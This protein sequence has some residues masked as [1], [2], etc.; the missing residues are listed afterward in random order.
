MNS[1]LSRVAQVTIIGDSDAPSDVCLA[2]EQIGSMCA[3]LGITVIT[4]GRGGVMEAA[5]KGAKN[6]GGISIGIIPTA[7]MDEANSWCSVIIPT[8]LGHARNVI[9]VLAGDFLISIGSSAGTLSEICFAWIHGKPI[10]MLSG[11]GVWGGIFGGNPLDS[12][13]ASVIAQCADMKQLKDSVIETC[14][15]LNLTVRSS[16]Q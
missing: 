16:I 1:K 15:R 10:L 9:T 5:N 2:A 12:R 7:E 3:Q 6:A 8:G 11:F 4:G 13:R 14:R